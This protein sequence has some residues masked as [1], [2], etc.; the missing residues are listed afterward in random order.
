MDAD[1]VDSL[2]LKLNLMLPIYVEWKK[3]FDIEDHEEPNLITF[4]EQLKDEEILIYYTD[5]ILQEAEQ[6]NDDHGYGVINLIR[7][8]IIDRLENKRQYP[9]TP[10]DTSHKNQWTDQVCQSVRD[11]ELSHMRHLKVYFIDDYLNDSNEKDL[12][13]SMIIFKDKTID[14]QMFFYHGTTEIHAQSIIA[15]GIRLVTT[16]S[17]PGDFGFGFYTANDFIDALRHAENRAIKTHGE[18]R[19]ACLV[20]SISKNE[21]NAYQIIRLLYEEKEEKFIRE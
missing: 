11:G 12:Q 18:Q 19:P 7:Y 8:S 6:W 16:G 10:F 21:F 9:I 5:S 3:Q 4:I 14:E 2:G 17:R 13:N 1:F 20:F 15:R